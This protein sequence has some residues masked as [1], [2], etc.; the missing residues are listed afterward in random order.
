MLRAIDPGR[1]PY[2]MTSFM[3]EKGLELIEIVSTHGY[4]HPIAAV[5]IFPFYC[6]F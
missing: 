2:S 4:S 6:K 5:A 3:E 1:D